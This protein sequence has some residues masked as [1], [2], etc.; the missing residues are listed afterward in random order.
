M[1]AYRNTMASTSP[2]R[3]GQ[4]ARAAGTVMV[5]FV[6]SRVAGLAREVII[7]ARFGTSAELDA[8]LAAFRLPDILFQ[9]VAG[10]ALA[11]AFLPTFSG[12]LVRND[13]AG[14]DR[15]ASGVINLLFL[16]LSILAAL[17]AL[18]APLLVRLVI[19]P[20]FPPEQQALTANLMR[21]MLLSTVVFGISGVVMAMLNAYQHFLLP[22]LAP[23]V[24]NL[25]IIAGA[26]FLA[27]RWGV[28]GLVMGVIVGAAGH[29]LVQIPEVA[30]RGWRW[31]PVL[32]L[33]EAGVREVGRLMGPRVLGLAAVQ[34]NFLVNTILASGLAV[35]SL[36]ALNYAWLLM[37]LPQGIVAQAIATAAFP[38]FATLAARNDRA[39]LRAVL[40]STLRGVTFLAMPATVGLII[41]REPLIRLLLQRGAFDER[42]TAAVAYV[43]TFFAA[44][45]VAHSVVEIVARAFYALH[46]TRTPV[47][48]GL[49]AMLG[50][51]F[52]SLLLIRP[53]GYGG[54]ALA[55]TLATTGEMA[56]L[57]W[58]IRG[59]LAGLEERR[60]GATVL[61]GV[62]ASG[63]L[64]LVLAGWMNRMGG[65]SALI[66]GAGGLALGALVYGGTAFVVGAEEVKEALRL[67]RRK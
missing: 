4:M 7:G 37:L 39:A 42:S 18:L 11:S 15:L 14:A 49:A 12:Y 30:R 36:A 64:A 67:V 19:A 32:G 35:G 29:L 44:G 8:Y 1:G 9:L 6:A 52:L 16:A 10:G 60:L 26:W 28:R 57:L 43:L 40:A 13:R 65:E 34:L 63:A 50:N 38:T 46:D 20:G 45:L 58:L 27:P 61:R 17:A 53:L 22:A 31:S 21:G 2:S 55:N 47:L 5:F 24:Y 3:A 48:V 23:V 56:V 51:V 25:A 41:L 33:R 66:V 59:R 54:L 62:L